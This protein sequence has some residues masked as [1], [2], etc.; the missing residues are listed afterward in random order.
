MNKKIDIKIRNINELEIELLANATAGDYI[1]LADLDSKT[2][3]VLFEKY[4]ESQPEFTDKIK[5]KAIAEYK[6]KLTTQP[7]VLEL[8]KKQK[9]SFEKVL[10][11]V[12][13]EKDDFSSQIKTLNEQM[14]FFEENKQKEID[15]EVKNKE[16]DFKLNYY[17]LQT[18]LNEL[19]QNKEKDIKNELLKAQLEFEQQKQKLQETIVQETKKQVK[20]EEEEK[21]RLALQPLEEKISKYKEETERLTELNNQLTQA[22]YQR[23]TKEIGE[24]FEKSIMDTLNELYG[25]NPYIKFYKTTVALDENGKSTTE[26]DKGTKPDFKIDFFSPDPEFEN[27]IIGSIVIEA[28]DQASAGGTQKNSSFYK[29]LNTDR[30]NFKADVAFLVTTLE[31][32]ET[33][34]V[35]NVPDYENLIQMRFEALPQMINIWQR[36][37]IEKAKLTRMDIQIEDKKKLIEKFDEFRTD[38]QKNINSIDK[39]TED[40]IKEIEKMETA[41]GKLRTY[42]E[43][44]IKSRFNAFVNKFKK[45]SLLK[46]LDKVDDAVFLDNNKVSTKQIENI[47]DAEVEEEI[48]DIQED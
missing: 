33:Y 8:L 20:Q 48:A 21:L 6:E 11:E 35:K 39:A 3:T 47:Q 26:K 17:K 10:Q 45:F 41:T 31:P 42:V 29:K 43:K 13:K 18:E 44:T 46:E 30:V 15:S 38:L 14:K 37:F 34:L 25:Y 5:E 16:A 36:L 22:K 12:K 1:S 19:K 7:E 4:K 28:K 23:S 32:N 2:M 24:D 27:K 40:M 9:D